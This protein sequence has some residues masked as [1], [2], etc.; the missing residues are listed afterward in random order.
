MS[1]SNTLTIPM[2]YRETIWWRKLLHWADD[3]GAAR[4][5]L[6]LLTLWRELGYLARAGELPGRLGV[7]EANSFLRELERDGVPTGDILA[8]LVEARLLQEAR[9]AA[10]ALSGYEC[11]LFASTRDHLSH[12]AASRQGGLNRGYSL[13]AR[14]AA[15]Q[16]EEASLLVDVK[17]WQDEHGTALAPDVIRRVQLFVAR[18]D[19]ALGQPPRP[20]Y[21]WQASTVLNAMPVLRQYTDPQ[22]A[23]ICRRI[24]MQRTHPLLHGQVT[25]KILPRFATVAAQ[26][27]AVTQL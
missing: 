14:R 23:E 9:D 1:A 6:V 24:F 17:I 25:E 5:A 3:G 12:A 8:S 2:D 4:A 26:V 21:A 15:A 20:A 10:G 27:G 16:A 7:V 13:A 22:L 11:P 19:S 18:L